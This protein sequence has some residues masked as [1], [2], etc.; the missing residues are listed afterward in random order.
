MPK[1]PCY[2][3]DT[4]WLRFNRSS[5][6]SRPRSLVWLMCLHQSDQIIWTFF[7]LATPHVSHHY[8]SSFVSI[9]SHDIRHDLRRQYYL[10]RKK[11]VFHENLGRNQFE[12]WDGSILKRPSNCSCICVLSILF[13][14]FNQFNLRLNLF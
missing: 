13:A 2:C 11:S 7:V 6:S 10:T 12:K 8:D 1:S 5:S 3:Q 14:K 9:L 4:P